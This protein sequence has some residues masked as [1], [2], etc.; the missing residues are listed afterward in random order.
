MTESKI[1]E[2]SSGIFV[3]PD[4]AN[5]LRSVTVSTDNT[6]NGDLGNYTFSIINENEM[7]SE[8]DIEIIPPAQVTF[9]LSP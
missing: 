9:S 8:S 6:I 4:T 3:K 1:D 2:N 5:A 7:P